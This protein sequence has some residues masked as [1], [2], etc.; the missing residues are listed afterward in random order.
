MIMLIGDNGSGGDD[1][2]CRGNVGV[3]GGGGSEGGGVR[4]FPTVSP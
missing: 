1:S 3:V 4:A 2:G